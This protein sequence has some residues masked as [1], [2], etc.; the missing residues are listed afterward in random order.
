MRIPIAVIASVSLCGCRDVTPRDLAKQVANIER[1]HAGDLS[2]PEVE[3]LDRH[4]NFPPARSS[5][6]RYF[7]RRMTRAFEKNDNDPITR[8]QILDI[9]AELDRLNAPRTIVN[10]A[11]EVLAEFGYLTPSQ[12]KRLGAVLRSDVERERVVEGRAIL[13]QKKIAALR[14]KLGV[15]IRRFDVDM[16]NLIAKDSDIYYETGSTFICALLDN[17]LSPDCPFPLVTREDIQDMINKKSVP[18]SLLQN[19]PELTF[20]ERKRISGY[21]QYLDRKP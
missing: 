9:I 7:Q 13:V 10:R 16:L 6:R 1:K 15:T 4:R 8:D 17:L 20:E 5:D 18:P 19:I 11:R 3:L 12:N 21:L 14:N 2:W